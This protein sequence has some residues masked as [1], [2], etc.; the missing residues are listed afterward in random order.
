MERE[1]IK[2]LKDGFTQ[3]E[4]ADVL[5]SNG[6]KPNSLRSIEGMLK[7]IRKKHN[8]KTMF[9]LGWELSKNKILSEVA[10]LK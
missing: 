1:I 7:S 9:Q 6:I 10:Q 2:L 8:C 5:K 4:I 3:P